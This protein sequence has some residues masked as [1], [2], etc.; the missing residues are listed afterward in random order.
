[1]PVSAGDKLGPYEILAPIGAGGMGEV[2]RARDTK[3]GR[4]VALKILPAEMAQDP[5]RLARFQREA[6]AAAALN[7]PNIVTLHSVEECAGVHFLT[8]ELVD[9]RTLDQVIPKG[10]FEVER[11][12]D[13]ACALAEALAAAHD[14]GLVHRD[15]KPANIMVTGDG[16]I[17]VLDF[18]LAKDVHTADPTDAT[19]TS[20]GQTQ[21]G[22]V[23]GTPPYM[24]PEQISGRALDHR[25]DIFSLGIILHEM[26]T[27]RR[28][29]QGDTSAELAA[30]ILRDN[31]P[32]VSGT[33]ADLPDALA[34]LIQQCLAK[35]AGERIQTA[36]LLAKGIQQARL[37]SAP[38]PTG[39]KTAPIAAADGGF[40]V[41]VLPFK[42][43]G[44]NSELEA[45]AEGLTEEIITGLSRFSY[46]RV[47]A[48]GSTLHFTADHIN[49]RAA[50]NELGARYVM[51]GSLR[52]AGSRLRVAV[53]LTDATTG[54]H[55]WAETY[56]RPFAADDV[57][58][59]Q[60]DLV[61][62][63][64]STVADQHGVLLHSMGNLIR[65]KSDAQLTAHEAA[66]RVFGFHERMSPEEHASV[67]ALL[68]RMVESAPGEGDCWAMLATIYSD[69]YMFGFAGQ[70]DPLKRAQAAAQRAVELAPSN[71]LACQALAQSLFFRREL[72]AFRPVAE[73]TIALNRM[74]GASTAFMG[75][76]LALSGD[77]ERGCEA[78]DRAMQLNPHYPGWYWLAAVFNSYR[79]RE[80]RA[81]VDA[82]LRINIPGYFWGPVTAA[83][84]FGQLGEREA[85]QKALRELLAIRPE[86]ATTAREEFGKWFDQE[87]VEHYVE[88]LVKAGLETGDTGAKAASPSGEA[89]AEEGFWVAVLPFK[90]T[91]ASAETAALA[92]GLSE[93]IETGLSRF[94]YLRVIARGSTLRYSNQASDLRTVG[95]ELGARYLISGSLRL[96][97]ARL[98]LTVQLSDATTGAQLWTETYERAFSAEA[99]FDIQDDVVPRIVSTVADQYG[100]LPRSM[101]QVVRAKPLDQLTPYEA[102]LRS[103]GFTERMTE[104]E[105]AAATRALE[106]AVEEAPADSDCWAELA[107]RYTSYYQH[108]FGARTDTL[109][110]ALIAARRAVDTAP[111]SHI[112]YRALA[113]AL[114]FRREVPA[115]RKAAER[116]V[117]LNPMDSAIL[118]Q[119]GSMLTLIGEWERGCALV[120][121]ARELNP[122]H[123]GW[124]WLADCWDAY[125]KGNYAG[126]LDAALKI[127]M[128]AFYWEPVV[129][130]AAYAQSG[131]KDEARQALADL[132]VLKPDF[133]QS[134]HDLLARWT[135]P[136][137]SS[138]L[139]DG[140]K[141]AGLDARAAG[142]SGASPSGAQ[143]AEEGFWVA[144]LPFKSAGASAELAALAEGLSE[145]IVTGLS[146]FSYLRVIGRGSTL[147]YARLTVDLRVAGRELGA[148]YI[149]EGSLRQAGSTLRVAVQ[150]IETTTGAHLWAETYD[151]PFR[152][153]ELFKLQDD[154]VPR[155][156]STVA[157]QQGI[158]PHS[159]GE[160]LRVKENARLTPHEAVLRAFSYFDRITPE[161]HAEVREI[162]EDAVAS[163]PGQSDCQAMLS[164]MYW[165][166]YAQGFNARPDSLARA[167]AAARRAVKAAPT[168]HLAHYTLA[169]TL[170]FQK[171]LLAFRPAA[172]HA[173]A[174]N[175]MA[176]ATNALL[177]LLIAFSGDWDRGCAIVDYA[178]ELNPHHPSWYSFAAFFKSYYEGE[179]RA[180][181]DAAFRINMP[182]Y[183]RMYA[184]QAAALGQLGEVE[185]AR[186][187]VSE[188]L[189]L[190]PDFAAAAREEFERW[191]PPELVERFIDGLRKAGLKIA[192]AP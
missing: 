105:Y 129:L 126:A 177:G 85:A 137:L 142:L 180:A 28:P 70:P 136:E 170:F 12:L 127:R 114:F 78:A 89:R 97:G 37:K 134:G 113:H 77:W 8:M 91:G 163:A 120:A 53:Q 16:R 184:A 130:A 123:P 140:L 14:K 60:D 69:E 150:L 66:L 72:Q 26:A 49:V 17:K 111:S 152:P 50:G 38:G 178:S 101:G 121:R 64:V 144:V 73:R 48:R 133:A 79:K 169:A 185:Q 1:M 158:L 161:E 135:D 36:R 83:A 54:T 102:L 128:P 56:D 3:L 176:G 116:A 71:W 33:R 68:E 96:A 82:A 80:Y 67:R 84:A 160:A 145:D 172:E 168:N 167:H 187:A 19:A 86:F 182:G 179:Y 138:Q 6:R 186:K 13:M 147:R 81:S 124:Y 51:E 153:D 58:A 117:E 34:S 87:L 118:A 189:G 155:I 62:K 22:V 43:R 23:M 175:R 157:D 154:L 21:M 188:L 125:R 65:T 166:E 31:P 20:V 92:E 148:R 59:L 98:R 76:L 25:S 156:V 95:K 93:E 149:M 115:F 139:M 18:G 165:H 88:G 29:F 55:L 44:G 75:L 151:R 132:I 30:S 110:R 35:D 15:L 63:I 143:R 162:L 173:I 42:Y 190:R 90:S 11:I 74:D 103:F 100:I 10:G 108:G 39:A 57:F 122:Y 9:G 7:H 40:W 141:N 24:S 159:M 61:P 109:D 164:I 146:R 5:D 183:F 32:P 94:S 2:Y 171:D 191:Y 104:E 52:Q 46:L 41:A 131:K 27:G 99:A 192:S 47:I 119:I 45:L 107:N 4:E 106:R 181:V 174:L 112:A